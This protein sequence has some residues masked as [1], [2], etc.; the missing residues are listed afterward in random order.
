MELHARLPAETG[1]RVVSQ[2]LVL[3]VIVFARCPLHK[4]RGDVG[5]Q[6]GVHAWYLREDEVSELRCEA[7][8]RW[9]P[10]HND[11]TQEL[12]QGL[13]LLWKRRLVVRGRAGM[14]ARRF[15]EIRQERLSQTHGVRCLLH[16]MR[17]AL[18]AWDAEVIGSLSHCHHK[19]VEGHVVILPLQSPA[20][21]NS[22]LHVDVLCKS[23]AVA[24]ASGGAMWPQGLAHILRIYSADGRRREEG[25]DEHVV[26]RRHQC[27]SI[28]RCV[29]VLQ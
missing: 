4:V 18:D 2:R 24:H 28:L 10:A 11:D 7:Y 3:R 29:D 8:A 12:A 20:L 1:K 5:S 21:H 17:V 16:E 22:L 19:T 9:P 6:L 26:P 14:Q 25:S 13:F 23:L 15:L 27:D